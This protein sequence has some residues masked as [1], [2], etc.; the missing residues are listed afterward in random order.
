MRRLCALARRVLGRR[1]ASPVEKLQTIEEVIADRVDKYHTFGPPRGAPREQRFTARFEPVV[2][3]CGSSCMIC[4]KVFGFD[5]EVIRYL[6]TTNSHNSL[7]GWSWMT[8]HICPDF[9]ACDQRR[10]HRLDEEKARDAATQLAESE[11][12]ATIAKRL[13]FLVHRNDV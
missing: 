10:Q 3:P 6:G 12:R 13:I 11:R 8:Y 2:G 5:D 9:N 4:R 7:T 1:P